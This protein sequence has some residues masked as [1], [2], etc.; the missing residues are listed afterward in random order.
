M[1]RKGSEELRE[2]AFTDLGLASRSERESWLQ[3]PCT[4]ALLHTMQGDIVDIL[5][6]WSD[7]SYTAESTS[8]T[9]QLNSEAIGQ[10]K[11]ASAVVDYVEGVTDEEMFDDDQS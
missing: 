4:R 5:E 6:A 9:I 3:H 8:G 7:G 1:F 11:A 10:F 2:M